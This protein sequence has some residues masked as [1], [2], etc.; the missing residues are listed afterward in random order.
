MM[1]VILDSLCEYVNIRNYEISFTDHVVLGHDAGALRM[2]LANPHR[3]MIVCTLIDG[4][5]S[6]AARG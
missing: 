1:L 4:E 2:A 6:A 3:R 5:Q